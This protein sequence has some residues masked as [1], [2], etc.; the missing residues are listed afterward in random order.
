[1]NAR[2]VVLISGSGTNLQALLDAVAQGRL[3]GKVVLVVSNRRSAYGLLRAEQAGVETLTFP[4]KPYRERGQSR[5]EYDRDLAEQ[6]AAA[7]PDLVVLAGWM[8]I[9]TPAFL[10]R[11]PDRV[12]NLHP[13]LPGQFAGTQ[14]IERAFAAFH[15]GEIEHSG[16]MVHVTVPEVD[17]G[18]VITQE[19]V[20]FRPGDTLES[21]A[22]RMHAAEH[23]IIVQAVQRML[24]EK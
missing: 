3:A 23:R 17:A 5:E 8:R 19:V 15:R 20:P 22:E 13:A 18:P 9:L 12:I 2:I 11:F 10:D 16:C 24:V 21:F 7:R 4:F 14:A 1:M 6:V